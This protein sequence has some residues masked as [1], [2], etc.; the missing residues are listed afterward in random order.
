MRQRAI[1]R[2]RGA[3]RTTV[4]ASSQGR[5]SDAGRTYIAQPQAKSVAK[6][7]GTFVEGAAL[8]SLAERKGSVLRVRLPR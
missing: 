4:R 2:P 6:H 1:R 5:S 8:A 7:K 3:G